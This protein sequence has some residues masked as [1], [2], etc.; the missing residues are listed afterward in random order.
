MES[1][2]NT[3]IEK[4]INKTQCKKKW[5]GID[6]RNKEYSQSLK[7]FTDLALGLIIDYD[8]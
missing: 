5:D 3:E 8:K 4:T 1:G 2:R 7:C 6:I